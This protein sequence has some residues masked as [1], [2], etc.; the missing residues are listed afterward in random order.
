MVDNPFFKPTFRQRALSPPPY[1][2]SSQS[3]AASFYNPGN[4]FF[5][6]TVTAS[7]QLTAALF[8]NS[9]S[10]PVPV[11]TTTYQLTASFYNPGNTFFA[12]N[13]LAGYTLFTPVLDNN[14][15]PQ[16]IYSPTISNGAAVLHFTTFST[17][18][19]FPPVLGFNIY[20]TTLFTNVNTFF[21][22]TTVRQLTVPFLNA[23]NTF[24]APQINRTLFAGLFTNSQ[25][26][27]SPL[28]TKTYQL[29]ASFMASGVVFNNHLISFNQNVVVGQ[30]ISEADQFYTATIK[31]VGFNYTSAMDD[32]V[33]KPPTWYAHHV[34][35]WKNVSE[36][37]VKQDGAWQQVYA[38]ADL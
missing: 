14:V 25:V 31:R 4:T 18:V 1:T 26:F 29:T 5:A 17:T 28:L 9:N 37:W 7:Y 19:I 30:T 6:P 27:H 38:Q 35:T 13:V 3:L 11:V 23:G 33:F 2:L 8:T 36:G 22:F 16:I 34:G 12:L 24:F 20:E 10:F 21:P 15:S 32:D